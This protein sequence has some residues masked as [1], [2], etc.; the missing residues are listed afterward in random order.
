M[1]SLTSTPISAALIDGSHFNSAR[2]S[3][4]NCVSDFFTLNLHL[5]PSESEP[6]PRIGDPLWARV[7]SGLIAPSAVERPTCMPLFVLQFRQDD[8]SQSHRQHREDR[9]R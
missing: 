3:C 1:P 4:C 2:T 9:S 6:A 7:H 8:V 5:C